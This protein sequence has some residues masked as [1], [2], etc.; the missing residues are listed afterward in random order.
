MP[1]Y[2]LV[3][4]GSP[5]FETK[6]AGENHMVQW[7]S[8]SQGLGDALID[9]GMPVGP[10]MTVLS[11]GSVS[12]G[13]GANPAV[14]ITILEAPSMSEAITMVQGCPHLSAG[15]TIEVAEAMNIE[16]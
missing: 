3:Y 2:V 8:W 15:G 1:K 10:S 6:E 5:R 13:G 7:R 14:G 9:P 4:H 12:E 11:D 16:M